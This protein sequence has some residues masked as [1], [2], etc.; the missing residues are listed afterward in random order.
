MGEWQW[1]IGAGVVLTVIVGVLDVSGHFF[2]LR[3]RWK[4]WRNPTATVGPIAAHSSHLYANIHRNT[5]PGSGFTITKSRIENYFT[6]TFRNEGQHPAYDFRPVVFA[7]EWRAAGNETGTLLTPHDPRR[8]R[9][10]YF[11]HW[12]FPLEERTEFTLKAPYRDGTGN[13]VYELR[14]HWEPGKE[15]Q[16]YPNWEP[17]IDFEENRKDD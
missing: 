5:G 4:E 2:G 1:L 7:K 17:I 13:R 16:E 10:D 6:I 8:F 14:F 11:P 15:G 9:F 12:E 3:D